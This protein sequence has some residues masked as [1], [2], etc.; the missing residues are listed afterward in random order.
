MRAW[1]LGFALT[2]LALGASGGFA[3]AYAGE[4]DHTATPGQDP[5][6]RHAKKD[7]ALGLLALEGGVVYDMGSNRGGDR[8]LSLDE[9]AASRGPGQY[10]VSGLVETQ[11][12]SEADSQTSGPPRTRS[13]R[14]RVSSAYAPALVASQ[15]TCMG[16]R[17]LGM[18]AMWFGV[19][20]ATTWEDLDCRRLNNARALN[21]LGYRGAAIALLCLDREVHDAMEQAGTPCLQAARVELQPLAPAPAPQAVEPPLATYS[22]LFDFDSSHL[23]PEADAVLAPLLAMLEA[24]PDMNV[25][26]EGHTDWVGSDA[27]N[28]GLSQRRAQ[29]VVDW[30]SSRGIARTRM[31]AVGKGE[32]E[33]VATNQTAAGRQLNRRTEVRR[34]D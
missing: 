30:L 25:D 4:N 33:P 10:D 15:D 32:R 18:Q 6:A 20:V 34:R 8:A 5:P 27:Y 28:L 31:R 19:S 9:K 1:T 11:S 13:R 26:I 16:S 23:R 24:E 22:V 17:S 29:A 21:A 14:I 2:T 3:P 12:L 7:L